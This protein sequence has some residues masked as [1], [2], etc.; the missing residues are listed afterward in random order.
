MI[1]VRLLAIAGISIL[2][3]AQVNPNWEK[4]GEIWYDAV[5]YGSEIELVHLYYDEFPTG[6]LKRS[7]MKHHPKLM[8]LRRHCCKQDWT[9]IL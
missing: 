8:E 9:K 1:I 6:E 4:R 2:T 5:K 7:R 3:S